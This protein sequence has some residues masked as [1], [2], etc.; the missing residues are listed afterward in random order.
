MSPKAFVLLFIAAVILL[1]VY[2]PVKN[3][4]YPVF[5]ATVNSSAVNDATKRINEIIKA[6]L[7]ENSVRYDTV[8]KFISS[9][10]QNVS[11]IQ[12]DTAVLNRIKSE[13]TAEVAQYFSGV[14]TMRADVPLGALFGSTPFSEKGPALPLFVTY[15]VTAESRTDNLFVT[16][17][18]NQTQHRIQ[19][20]I[21][22]NTQVFL[23]GQSQSVPL[24][25]QFTIAETVI[26]GQIPEIYAGADD[27]LWP[28]LVG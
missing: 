26:I 27:E 11:A 9:A 4:F 20:I 1:S 23:F 8:A 25:T 2:I 21:S 12:I 16:S 18:I 13:I 15:T 6:Y 17:G 28:N 3:V 19:L 22:A 10:G 14:R 7:D 24:E 5:A